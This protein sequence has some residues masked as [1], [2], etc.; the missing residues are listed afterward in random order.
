MA[1]LL[2]RVTVEF[3]RDEDRLRMAG[4]TKDGQ[5]VVIWLTRRMLALLL[6]VLLEHLDDQFHAAAPEHRETLQEFAQQAA[7]GALDGSDP[8]QAADDDGALLP[9]AIDVAQLREGG[10]V[11]TFRRGEQ[12]A[13][14][15]PLLGPAL[16][17]WIHI[18]FNAHRKAEWHLEQWPAWLAGSANPAQGDP[19]H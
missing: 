4:L 9:N 2:K 6:P 19:L 14:R 1:P 15:L 8:V 13:Y 16:R 11:L 10:I 5:P 17:Q 12:G 3:I 18:L 7:I